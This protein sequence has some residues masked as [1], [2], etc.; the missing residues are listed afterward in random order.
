ML[1]TREW[2]QH[3]VIHSKIQ[4]SLLKPRCPTLLIA[5]CLLLARVINPKSPSCQMFFVSQ[6]QIENAAQRFCC[7]ND[8]TP[9]YEQRY[10]PLLWDVFSPK[11]NFGYKR[12]C[13]EDVHELI[14]E[15]PWLPTVLARP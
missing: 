14:Q 4:S 13:A 3:D 9:S 10:H 5:P 6:Q 2:H 8:M 11:H 15:G 1:D 7:D 12:F